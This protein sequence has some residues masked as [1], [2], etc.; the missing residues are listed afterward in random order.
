[1][2]DFNVQI[3][4]QLMEVVSEPDSSLSAE[5]YTF[6]YNVDTNPVDFTSGLSPS[7]TYCFLI[8]ACNFN[9]NCINFTWVA[10]TGI[11]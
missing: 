7:T 5:H 8:K 1:M 9:N 3:E 10:E 6:T 4:P 11:F 2:R